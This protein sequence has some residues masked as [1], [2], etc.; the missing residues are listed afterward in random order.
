M[1]DTSERSNRVHPEQEKVV[2]T[3]P[4]SFRTVKEFPLYATHKAHSQSVSAVSVL[5]NL[6]N[7]FC[8]VLYITIQISIKFNLL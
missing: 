2:A 1:D 5:E 4:K 6:I 8:V 3:I 7:M